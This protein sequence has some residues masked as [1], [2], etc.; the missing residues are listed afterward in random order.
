MGPVV[1]VVHGKLCVETGDG[2]HE[3]LINSPCLPRDENGKRQVY[4]TLLIRCCFAS[5]VPHRFE[6]AIV[7]AFDCSEFA[8]EVR[9]ATQ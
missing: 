2:T 9:L 8:D 3:G 5:S 4:D 7:R 1:E 6:L